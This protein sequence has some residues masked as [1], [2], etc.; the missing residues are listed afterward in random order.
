MEF[1]ILMPRLSSSSAS[2]CSVEAEVKVDPKWMS[3]WCADRVACILAH[4]R[5]C[6][7]SSKKMAQ[8][9]KPLSGDLRD[10]LREVV[11]E[12]HPLYSGE[13]IKEKL[14]RSKVAIEIAGKD[15]VRK[16]PSKA[17]PRKRKACLRICS[18]VVL[19]SIWI[20]YI[21]IY[22]IYMTNIYIERG[23]E[24]YSYSASHIFLNR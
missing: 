21:Y 10:M 20:K 16:S 4:V 8:A 14:E 17:S 19:R 12:C 3:G 6:A 2:S 7:L 24:I 18:V 13:K 1:G 5:R 11:A 9:C 22:I 15:E 23:S